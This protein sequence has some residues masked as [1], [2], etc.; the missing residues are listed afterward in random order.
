MTA[1]AAS[2]R[3]EILAAA[4]G[5]VRFDEPMSRHTTFHIGGSA[6]VWAEPENAGELARLVRLASEVG[7]PLT[8]VG[9]GANLLVRDEG[10]PG[11]VICL[12]R[13]A[14]QGFS[15]SSAPSPLTGEGGGEGE[16]VSAGAALPLEW[17][18]RETRLRGLSGVEFLAGVPGR[19]GGAVRMNAGTRD[20]EGK[21]HAFSDVIRFITVMDRKGRVT[22]LSREEAGFGYRCSRL[23]GRIVLEAELALRPSDPQSVGRRMEALWAFK[24]RTQ[25]WSS[26]SVGCIFKN[27]APLSAGRLLEEAGLKGH[28]VG[29]AMVSPTHANFIMNLG[30][31]RAADVLALIEEARARVLNRF[32]QALELE[33]QVIPKGGE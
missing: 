28:R 14:F 18:L 5:R 17:L 22:R 8:I 19:V 23:D 24:K 1:L 16:I 11:L 20:L 32:G 25:D 29:D 10:I 15:S 13:P 6:E 31:A 7:L 26:P 3:E 2:V 30:S 12:S 27:P 4:P 21:T 9:G 33:V